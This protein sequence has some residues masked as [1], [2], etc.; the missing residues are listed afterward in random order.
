MTK[1]RRSS[2][3]SRKAA[4]R[5]R[6]PAPATPASGRRPRGRVP[7][8]QPRPRI[9]TVIFD[10][11]DT[12]YDCYG[13]RVA[14][15]HR[16]AAQ[17]MVGAGLPATVDRAF[18]LRMKAY[19]TDPQLHHIDAE[20]CRRLGVPEEKAEPMIRAARAAFFTAPV[21]KLT[22]FPETRKVLAALKRRGVKIFVVSFG[23]SETQRAKVA[24]L[25]LDRE[26][27]IDRIFYADTGHVITKEAVFRSLLRNAEPD[28]GRV[29][30][31][32]DRPSSEIRA[33]KLLGM[34]TVRMRHGEFSA[35]QPQG[36][37]EQADFEIRK[38]DA[39]LKLPLRFGEK[40]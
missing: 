1:A 20:V 39:L 38:L 34:H 21:G 32:G 8:G 5:L 40:D 30:V 11:D 19:K 14:A 2:R 24:A 27:A 10:L 18:R 36:P 33:G 37:E 7:R 3:S 25:G 23:D 26:P 28:P 17:A 4:R 6:R 15:A 29:L 12:L 31:V 35:L 13:Q 22:L 9:T 16:H